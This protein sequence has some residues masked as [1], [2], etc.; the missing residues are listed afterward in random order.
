MKH[1]SLKTTEFPRNKIFV[2][3]IFTGNIRV[4]HP[5]GS[6]CTVV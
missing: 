6:L 4:I 5:N 2:T 1:A 3:I